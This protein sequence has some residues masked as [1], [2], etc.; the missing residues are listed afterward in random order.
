MPE[1]KA[2][3]LPGCSRGKA[4]HP[5][6]FRGEG[7]SL[8]WGGEGVGWAAP[9]Q[10]SP[11]G[12]RAGLQPAGGTARSGHSP[13]RPGPPRPESSG[14]LPQHLE[15]E[16]GVNHC[17]LLLEAFALLQ[18]H[19]ILNSWAAHAASQLLDLE[20]R[21]PHAHGWTQA[22]PARR[23]HRWKWLQSHSVPD[24]NGKSK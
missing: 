3:V 17:L 10:R 19:H 5:R 13:A 11:T 22:E 23:A 12:E 7:G 6:H 14:Q 8:F 1:T 20:G 15:M 4:E 24:I 2:H 21:Q 16:I 18:F 9:I